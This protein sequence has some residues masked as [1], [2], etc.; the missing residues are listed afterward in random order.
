MNLPWLNQFTES[1][2]T[3]YKYPI[4]LCSH[5]AHSYSVSA[6]V[7][8]GAWS[9]TIGNQTLYVYEIKGLIGFQ[10][11][12]HDDEILDSGLLDFVNDSVCNVYS[13][14]GKKV[15]KST[16]HSTIEVGE[17]QAMF[18]EGYFGDD[19]WSKRDYV[20]EENEKAINPYCWDPVL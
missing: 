6:K 3:P 16:F 13:R 2:L 9:K 4:R 18:I 1:I 12:D 20:K 7:K 11:Q 15:G 19:F 5:L 14:A 10:I 8:E 17:T